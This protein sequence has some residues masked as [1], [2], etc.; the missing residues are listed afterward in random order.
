MLS[1]Q[2]EFN[3]VHRRFLHNVVQT[4]GAAKL[5][6]HLVNVDAKK[7]NGEIVS[8]Q[9]Y[10][11]A[12]VLDY[13]PT[14][15]YEIITD[16]PYKK[17]EWLEHPFNGL[18]LENCYQVADHIHDTPTTR[19][20]I[21]DLVLEDNW[22]KYIYSAGLYKTDNVKSV[23]H[24]CILDLVGDKTDDATAD[25]I[26]VK[27]KLKVHALLLDNNQIALKISTNVPIKDGEWWDM[28]PFRRIHDNKEK[29][30]YTGILNDTPAVR[31]M[32]ND[33]VTPG[34]WKL[35]VTYDISYREG[36]IE[37]LYKLFLKASEKTKC[38][39]INDLMTCLSVH[40]S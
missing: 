11:K 29:T 7:L 1:I 22:K 27:L 25:S 26:N 14:I 21:E 36:L 40:W 38:K 16:I 30:T 15:Y 28:H 20:I 23:I 9:L 5:V 34:K 10:I 24:N 12:E 3:T 18:R 32:L 31:Q 35:Y 4:T 6:K 37:N 8:I 13:G 39:V 2:R 19:K 33:L 17:G